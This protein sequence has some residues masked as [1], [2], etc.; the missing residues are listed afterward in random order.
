MHKCT[1]NACKSIH[2]QHVL[3]LCLPAKDGFQEDQTQVGFLYAKI[4]GFSTLLRTAYDLNL[5]FYLHVRYI[6]PRKVLLA[7]VKGC[8]IAGYVQFVLQPS[9]KHKDILQRQACLLLWGGLVRLHWL[10]LQNIIF[11]T[12]NWDVRTLSETVA[13]N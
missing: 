12:Q 3:N 11:Y 7:V 9:Y 5:D 10:F 8:I 4:D 1:S 6:C 13:E 2:L